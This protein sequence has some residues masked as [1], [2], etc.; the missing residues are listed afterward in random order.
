MTD[1]QMLPWDDTADVG[2]FDYGD[3]GNVPDIDKEQYNGK[4]IVVVGVSDGKFESDYGTAARSLLHYMPDEDRVSFGPWGLLLSE[5]SPAITMA[6][7]Q[8]QKNGGRPF[9]ARIVKKMGK[10]Y[11]YWLL[12]P[13]KVVFTES[14]SIGGFRTRS[15]EVITNAEA[16]LPMPERKGRK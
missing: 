5:T 10:T 2:E 14:G 4:V 9:Y 6:K 13:V 16:A 3:L 1:S 15:G 11:P 8:L 12:E 7:G